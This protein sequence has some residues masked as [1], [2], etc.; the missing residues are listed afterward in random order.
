MSSYAAFPQ[1]SQG[2]PG[3]NLD[4]FFVVKSAPTAFLGGTTDSRGDDG[5]A[6]DPL[7]VFSVVG[8]VLVGI[9]GVVSVDLVSAGGGTV[10]VGLTDNT[11]LFMPA[12]TATTLDANE[13]WVGSA[14]PAIGLP[15]DNL[16]FY[17]VGNG[18]DVVE[19]TG[20]ADITAGNIYYLAI[21][22][23][24]SEDGAVLAA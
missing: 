17:V 7:S 14:T 1:D 21:W 9:V 15:V 12:T 18:E 8:D 11:T 3:T 16:T 4:S 2:F 13:V 6:N 5:G 10:S 19:A 24:I 20:T 22:R 23:P